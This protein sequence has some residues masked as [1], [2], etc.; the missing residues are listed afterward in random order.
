MNLKTVIIVSFFGFLLVGGTLLI[1]VLDLLGFRKTPSSA[2]CKDCNV[3]LIT[4]TSLRYDHMSGNGYE[5]PTTPNLDAF[6]NKSLVFDSA[7]AHSSWTL[8]EAISIYTSLY[9]YQHGIMSRQKGS[10]LAGGTPALLDILNKEGYE[11]AGF[12][13]SPWQDYKKDFGL[14]NRFKK[15]EE[16]LG[17]SNLRGE[18]SSSADFSCTVPKALKW[19]R[20]NTSRKF[21]LHIQG[22]DAHCPYRERL[23]NIYDKDYSGKIDFNQCFRT[24]GSTEPIVRNGKTYYSV[25]SS[26]GNSILLSEADKRHLIA[27]YDE[28]ITYTD[29]LVGDFLDEIERMGLQENTIIIVTSEHGDIFGEHGRFMRG[30]PLRGTFYDEVLHVPLII[31]HPKLLP[32]HISGLVGHIDIVPTLLNFLDIK[33]KTKFEGKSMLPLI[34]KNK[35]INRAVFAGSEFNSQRGNVFFE[36]KSRVEAIRTKQWK[37]IQETTFEDKKAFR[38]SELYDVLQDKVE[39]NNLLGKRNDVLG[40]LQKKLSDW[41]SAVR[42]KNKPLS[43]WERILRKIKL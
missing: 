7:F 12:T 16:C 40:G 9:P 32:K 43:P 27:L 35:E 30:G 11:T 34:L 38:S 1:F 10:S 28:T 26:D 2:V 39:S 23:G 42:N 17:E 15:H 31:K 3:I 29:R 36:P 18:A 22:Y 4:I 13:G 6:A 20:E 5:R 33:V 41:S 24:Y 19:L 14:T 25:S 37:L 21:F 8:P